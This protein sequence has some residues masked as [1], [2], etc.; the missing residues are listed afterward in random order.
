M[1]SDLPGPDPQISLSELS[2]QAAAATNESLL[3]TL[4]AVLIELERRLL[5]YSHV[6]AEMVAMADEGL[7][8]AARAAA[9]LKQTQSA[10]S[11][12]IGHLQVVGVGEWKPRTTNP[13]WG[14]DPRVTGEED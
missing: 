14:D 6:G 10:A 1:N 13:S 12:T 5:H 3:A 7:V 4:D 11:H 9:R 2:R 8:L